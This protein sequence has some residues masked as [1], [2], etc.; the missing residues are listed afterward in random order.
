MIGRRY[1]MLTV[2]CEAPARAGKKGKRWVCACSCTGTKTVVRRGTDLRNGSAKHCGC[3]RRLLNEFDRI[4][5]RA[6]HATGLINES[7]LAR[8]FRV[9]PS[10][11]HYVLAGDRKK[12][13]AA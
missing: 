10:S 5:M 3:A 7:E 11:V 6:L 8:V 13:R 1:D 4:R 12:G 9:D 2:I